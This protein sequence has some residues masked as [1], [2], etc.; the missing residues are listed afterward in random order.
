[1]ARDLATANLTAMFAR[2]E[3]ILDESYSGEEDEEDDLGREQ[4]EQEEQPGDEI[5]RLRSRKEELERLQR[6]EMAR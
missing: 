1:M 6:E 4:L 3:D 2:D 5:S